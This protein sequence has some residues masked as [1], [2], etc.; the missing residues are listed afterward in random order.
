[1]L[2][3]CLIVFLDDHDDDDDDDDDDGDNDDDDDG[4]GND[5]GDG[6]DD[7]DDDDRWCHIDSLS[8]YQHTSC[9]I[10]SNSWGRENKGNVSSNGKNHRL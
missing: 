3:P 9:L 6:G 2:R 4:D 5:D 7:D 10:V 1:M 8:L